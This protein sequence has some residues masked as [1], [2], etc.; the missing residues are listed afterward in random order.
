MFQ[1]MIKTLPAL[2]NNEYNDIITPV[3]QE[4]VASELEITLRSFVCQTL[5]KQLAIAQKV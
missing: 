2:Y 3:S 4:E 5:Q 1:K